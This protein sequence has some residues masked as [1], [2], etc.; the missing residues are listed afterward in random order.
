MK[1]AFIM[2]NGFSRSGKS[3][4]AKRIV[5]KTPE[6]IRIDSD[7]IHD[8]LN[9]TYPVFQDEDSIDGQSY[10]L[11][12]LTTKR[13]Q[14]TLFSV[15]L[16]NGKSIIHDSCNLKKETRQKVLDLVKKIDKDIVTIVIQHKIAEKALYK[17]IAKADKLK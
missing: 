11:R 15:L 6:L 3:T 7:D 12:Q 10:D 4:L 16:E 1:R 2:M 14:I 9:K 13:I 5:L 17:N 8:F